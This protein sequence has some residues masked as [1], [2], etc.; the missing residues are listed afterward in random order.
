MMPDTKER[1]VLAWMKF[2]RFYAS[3]NENIVP[4]PGE[5]T[6]KKE[7]SDENQ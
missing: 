4:M 1:Q 2:Q 5:G 7:D 6:K 3:L